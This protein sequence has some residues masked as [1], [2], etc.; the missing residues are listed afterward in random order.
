MT[1]HAGCW[2]MDRER[3][4]LTGMME[5]PMT[6]EEMKI[7][8]TCFP[9]LENGMICDVPMIFN[10]FVKPRV[11]DTTIVCLVPGLSLLGEVSRKLKH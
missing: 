1:I 4:T 10:T 3:H 6:L 11:G 5:N 9:L 8:R 2:L 7:V